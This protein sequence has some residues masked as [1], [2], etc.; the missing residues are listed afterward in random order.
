VVASEH[1]AFSYERAG[2]KASDVWLTPRW[3]LDYLGKFDL[4]PCGY[5]NWFTA[6]QHYCWPM[7][8]GLMLPWAGRIWCNPPYGIQAV[9][10]AERMC[11]HG[12]GLLLLFARTETQMF[13]RLW[14]HASA[15]LF[16]Y[17][18]VAFVRPD[19]VT[20]ESGNAPSVLV[21]F[22]EINADVLREAKK[23]W[24]TWCPN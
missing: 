21:A 1:S 24:I 23:K 5:P 17:G 22:G 4:D 13:Q 19:G 20:A 15:M 14:A 7:D 9:A 8:D 6:D 11:I 12:N 16:L 3:L 18:R 10:W 2:E